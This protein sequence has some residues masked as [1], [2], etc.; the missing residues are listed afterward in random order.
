MVLQD[1]SQQ[2]PS[3]APTNKGKAIDYFGALPE[4]PKPTFEF[5]EPEIG[6]PPNS[7]AA[8]YEY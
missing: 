3:K 7:M 8:S 1:L 4:L 5:D 2:A 6:I